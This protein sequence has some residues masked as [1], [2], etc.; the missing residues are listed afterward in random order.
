MSL[1][2]SPKDCDGT[3]HARS[4]NPTPP[5]T[6]SPRPPRLIGFCQTNVLW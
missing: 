6:W 1:R 4:A 5:I 2:T 3:G